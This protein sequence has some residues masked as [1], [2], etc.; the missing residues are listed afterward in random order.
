MAL[1]YIPLVH[2]IVTMPALRC[3]LPHYHTALLLLALLFF[4]VEKSRAECECLWQGSF[5]QAATQA[6][7]IVSGIVVSRKGNAFDLQIETIISGKEF[8]ETIRVWADNGQ[9]CRPPVTEFTLQS[10][11]L[12]AVFKITEVPVGAFNPN[13]PSIS[14]GRAEDY[15]LSKCGAYWLHVDNGYVSGNLING[16]RWQWE[17]KKMNPVLLELIDAY[18][19]GILPDAALTEAAKPQTEAKKLMEST[20]RFIDRQ[21]SL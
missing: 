8:R 4:P 14:Y 6:D 18:F 7:L 13:T 2:V 3:P 15:Y 5:N 11:W 16:Q 19:K 9:L 1:A 21:Q 20:Q 17:N 10:Q 12:L